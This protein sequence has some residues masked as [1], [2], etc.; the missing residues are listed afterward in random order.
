M[1]MMVNP[2]AVVAAGGGGGGG[3]PGILAAGFVTMSGTTPTLNRQKNVSSS[4]TRNSAGDYTV[5][6]S[7]ALAHANYFVLGFA[8]AVD[9]ASDGFMVVTAKAGGAY[10]TASVQI[11]V[12]AA[13]A[14]LTDPL[15][16][17]FLIVDAALL[18]DADYLAAAMWTI[19]GGVVTLEKQLNMASVARAAAGRYTANYASALADANYS[20]FRA[21]RFA[22]TNLGNPRLSTDRSIGGGDNSYT[23]ALQDFRAWTS[24]ATFGEVDKGGVLAKYASGEVPGQVA[25]VRFDGSGNIIS[26]HNVSSVVN[27]GSSV[28]RVTFTTPLPHAENLVLCTAKDIDQ[29]SGSSA[30]WA[31]PNPNTTSSRGNFSTTS[32]DVF[33]ATVGGTADTSFANADVWV[34]DPSLA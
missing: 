33:V 15:Y 28:W 26:Q 29:A 4:I 27:Q 7:S 2:Y 17:G 16:W 6:F 13:P 8:R 23:S 1:S 19:S 34:I 18:A 9:G 11:A 12:E 32:V 25:A 22:A 10:S 3:D 30:D 31:G 24:S 20:S 14:T 5:S 21:A